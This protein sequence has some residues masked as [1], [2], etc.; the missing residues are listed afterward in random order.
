M[1][2]AMSCCQMPGRSCPREMRPTPMAPM[3]MRLLGDAGPRT[4]A[5]TIAGNPPIADEAT[6]P[7]PAVFRKLRRD[8]C[9]LRLLAISLSRHFGGTAPLLG[10]VP[11]AGTVLFP[12]AAGF[13]GTVA[14]TIVAFLM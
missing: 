9:G 3:L 7:A 14:F 8:A 4:E 10:T 12:G 11:F 6:R 2:R 5:G 1:M 13:A